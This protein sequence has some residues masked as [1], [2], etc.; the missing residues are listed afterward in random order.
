ML[1]LLVRHGR[2]G[3]SVRD[4]MRQTLDALM[5]ASETGQIESAKTLVELGA[6]LAM[7]CWGDYVSGEVMRLIESRSN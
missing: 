7:V 2:H 1:Q 6:P 4:G 5:A 3:I